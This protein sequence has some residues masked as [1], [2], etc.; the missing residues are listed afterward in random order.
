MDNEEEQ[1]QVISAIY[2]IFVNMN[3][4]NLSRCQD[5]MDWHEFDKARDIKLGYLKE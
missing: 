4:T 1:K 3:K 5:L 2:T